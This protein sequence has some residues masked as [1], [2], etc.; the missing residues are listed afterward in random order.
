V[1][2]AHY[3]GGLHAEYGMQELWGGTQ[4]LSL[5]RELKLPLEPG[6]PA[7]SSVMIDGKLT[8]FTQDSTP[9][10]LDELFS[11]E[12]QG[13][14]TR[15][16]ARAQ[17]LRAALERQSLPNAEMEDLQ[18]RSFADWVKAEGLPHRVEEFARLTIEC[19]L[20]TDWEHFSAASGLSEF[21]VFLEDTPNYRIQGGNDRLIQG[22]VAATPGPK[23]LSATV[24]SVERSQDKS[25]AVRA[26]VSYL[27][28]GRVQTL[29]AEKVVVAVPFF[30]L[31]QIA[32]TPPL[33]LDKWQGILTLDRGGYTVVHLMV[34][35]GAAAL[36]QVHGKSP[37]PVLSDGPLGVIYGVVDEAPGQKSQVFSLL[38]HGLPAQAFHMAPREQKLGEIRQALDA[39][40]PGF[41]AH[42]HEGYVYSY[43]PAA[44]AVW[45][46]GR[47]PFDGPARALREPEMGVY[48][49][50]DWT[51]SAHG[52]GA[53][54]S[55]FRAAEAVAR[56]LKHP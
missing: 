27:Q 10:Y 41:S 37:F 13:A 48:L 30:R 45:P 56:D 23:T 32:F 14:W 24:L 52:S 34:D 5:A 49:A 53:V 31:H 7:L 17:K 25:G 33:S 8:A 42:V 12:E 21:G 4:L 28:G 51:V 40:W 3:P 36:A 39:L 29:E 18:N 2:T 44:V 46:P 47:S 6:E 55:A 19:E 20:A 22:L 26:R 43:H 54:D 35:E 9:A 16:T 11:K 1:A 38:V 15:W 50:G